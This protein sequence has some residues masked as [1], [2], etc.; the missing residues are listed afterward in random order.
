LKSLHQT[1]DGEL[2]SLD[3]DEQAAFDTGLEIR[4]RA[5]EMLEEHRRVSEIFRRR[6]E[7]VKRVYA[8]LRAGLGD[9][10]DI[11]R[12]THG[13]ARDRALRILD[14]R[15]SG[16]L[17]GPSKDRVDRLVRLDGDTARRVVVTENEHYRNAFMK[18]STMVNGALHLNEEERAAIQQWEEYRAMGEVSQGAGGYGIP[19]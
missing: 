3:S 6:P 2:R 13:E 10:G 4:E 1:D 8:N 19:V 14:S 15:E 11:R 9:A 5:M 12:L 16:N 7:S 18:L 17:S